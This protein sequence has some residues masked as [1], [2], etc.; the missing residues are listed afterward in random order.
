MIYFT[1]DWHLDHKNIIKYCKRP[2][3]NCEEME[4]RILDT[5][6]DSINENDIV[7]FLGDIFWNTKLN[8]MK[9]ILDSLPGTKHLIKG[10]HDKAPIR[11][12]LEAGFV[13][14]HKTR[15]VSSFEFKYSCVLVHDPALSQMDRNQKYLCGHIH[16]LFVVKK[17]VLNVGVDV[18]NYYPVPF[19]S[20]SYHFD[21]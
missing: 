18:W 15:V 7:Y 12:Y 8:K 14:V 19:F 2:F 6:R 1:A 11:R 5:Y 9:S 3:H 16:D 21:A 4:Q 20:V 10:N 13:S 17:N